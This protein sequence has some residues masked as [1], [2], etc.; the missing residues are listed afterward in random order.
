MPVDVATTPGTGDTHELDDT[1]GLGRD[2][3]RDA[4][5]MAGRY[6]LL[7]VLAIIVLFPIYITVVNSLLPSHELLARPPKLFPSSPRWP[8]FHASEYESHCGSVGNSD[9]GRAAI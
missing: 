2:R 6:A 8:W 1:S 3:V 9:G 7:T 5:R 4:A